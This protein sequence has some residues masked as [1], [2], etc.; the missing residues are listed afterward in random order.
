MG[1]ELETDNQRFAPDVG[2]V[3]EVRFT[4][5]ETT[6]L[7]VYVTVYDGCDCDVVAPPVINKEG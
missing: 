7:I 4:L 3:D 1:L 6:E 2:P 5:N